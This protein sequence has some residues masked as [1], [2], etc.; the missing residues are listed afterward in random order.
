M[1]GRL[2]SLAQQRVDRALKYAWFSADAVERLKRPKLSL[3]VAIPVRMDNGD[4]KVF[5][6]YRVRSATPGAIQAGARHE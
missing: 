3:Q 5:H 6:D 1:S 2:L 4:L